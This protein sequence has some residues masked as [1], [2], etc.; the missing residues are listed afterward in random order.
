MTF[1]KQDIY[2]A[3]EK[4]TEPGGGKNL[5]ENGNVTNVVTFGDEV[6]VDVTINNPSLQA[7]KKIEVEI[8]PVGKTPI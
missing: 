5:V 4:I 6:I 1:K 2:N 3:L 7:K 8:I